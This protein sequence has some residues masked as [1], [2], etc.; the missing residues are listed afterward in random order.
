[1]LKLTGKTGKSLIVEAIQ[2]RFNNSRV[3]SYNDY[4][5][6]TMECYHVDLGECSV[7]EF[8]EFVYQDILKLEKEK[9]LN[10]VIVIYTNLQ[11]IEEIEKLA[12]KLE[13]EYLVRMVVVTSR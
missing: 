1:M 9:P 10:D 5:I 7:N 11:Q 3:Y 13:S 4:M 2:N 8:C 6:P 12:T